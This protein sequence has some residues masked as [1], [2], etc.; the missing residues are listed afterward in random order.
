MGSVDSLPRR[1]TGIGYILPPTDTDDSPRVRSHVSDEWGTDRLRRDIE[2]GG[3]DVD[4][5][6]IKA[7]FARI[8]DTKLLIDPEDDHPL[9]PG[10]E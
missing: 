2:R 4:A 1:D 3:L 5:P 9:D 10:V 7:L 6:D 8:D